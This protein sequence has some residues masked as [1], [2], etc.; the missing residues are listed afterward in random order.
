MYAVI[1]LAALA[2]AI[3]HGATGMAGGIVLVAIL[4]HIIGVKNA[5]PLVSCALI[6]SHGSRVFLYLHDIDWR[7]VK[8]VLL[9]SP[10]GVVFG[11]V[12]FSYLP[13]SIIAAIMALFLGLSFPL[14]AYFRRRQMKTSDSVLAGAST[15]WGALAGNVIGPGFVL[16]PFL[17][18]REMGRLTF[19]GSLA[20]IVLTM[21]VLKVAVF[22]FTELINADLFMLGLTIGLVTIPGNWLGKKLLLKMSDRDHGLIINIMTAL[23]ILNFLYLYIYP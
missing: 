6:F 23:I 3:L 14:K 15:L 10:P 19:V 2:T 13:P 12:V 11:A 21:N 16:A 4:S 9:F 17:L 8:I 22:G 18:G 20:F 1:L 5:V 7:S